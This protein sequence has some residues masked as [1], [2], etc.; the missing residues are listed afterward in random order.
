VALMSGEA[1]I[2]QLASSGSLAI[3]GEMSVMVKLA[4]GKSD[5]GWKVHWRRSTAVSG[6]AIK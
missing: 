5:L 4:S 1:I 6:K 3:T 2:A